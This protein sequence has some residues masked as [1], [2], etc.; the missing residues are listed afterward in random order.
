MT[1]KT[2]GYLHWMRPDGSS[3]Q[4][5]SEDPALYL[6]SLNIC[7]LAFYADYVG[8]TRGALASSNTGLVTDG[9]WRCRD[10]DDILEVGWY[11]GSFDDSHWP[12]ALELGINDGGLP[13]GTITSINS[14][15]KLIW[16]DYN[17]FQTHR[18]YCR[19]NLCPGG[20]LS[21]NSWLYMYPV[22]EEEVLLHVCFFRSKLQ[23]S[24]RLCTEIPLT[25]Q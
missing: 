16:T 10:N 23:C 15:A 9:T 7:H 13:W 14:T 1:L 22:T 6:F 19:K 8:G 21:R 20:L 25:I 4:H 2:D 17:A 12:A 3:V 5:H 11:L 24:V 18:V